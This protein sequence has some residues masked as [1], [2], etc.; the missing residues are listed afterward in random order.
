MNSELQ[1]DDSPD[2]LEDQSESPGLQDLHDELAAA[3]AEWRRGARRTMEVM[4]EF[5]TALDSMGS[6]VRDLHTAARSAPP[7]AAASGSSDEAMHTQ[8]DLAD[9]LARLSAAFAQPPAAAGSCWPPAR[10]ALAA[11]AQAWHSQAEALAILRAHLEDTLAR[12][13][14]RRLEAAGTLFD[15]ATMTAVEAVTRTDVPDH[16]VVEVLLPGWQHQPTGRLLR[17]AQVRVARRV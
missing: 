1:E 16:T 8:M 12:S 4:K 14:L 10:R 11:W 17:P 3:T 7:P 5:G 9:R 13:G 2:E 15:P 6:M